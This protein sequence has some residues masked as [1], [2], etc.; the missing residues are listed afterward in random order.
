ML[1]VTGRYSALAYSK[2]RLGCRDSYRLDLATGTSTSIAGCRDEVSPDGL[3][4]ATNDAHGLVLID[5]SGSAA[6]RLDDPVDAAPEAWSPD[7]RW[8]AWLGSF[9]PATGRP[10]E[11]GIVSA[12]GSHRVRLPA[13]DDA[14][15]WPSWSPD[16][17]RV[18]ISTANGTLV[19]RGDGIELKPVGHLGSLT[20]APNGDRFA[21]L[22]GGDLWIARADGTEPTNLTRFES[23]GASAV[24]WSPDGG[25]I[26]VIQGRFAWVVNLYG[27][28]HA[29]DLGADLARGSLSWSPSGGRLAIDVGSDTDPAIDLVSAD[30]TAIA[31]I[32]GAEGPS[33]SPTE[34]YVA[35][36]VRDPQ[37]AGIGVAY[38]DG[39]GLRRWRIDGNVSVFPIRWI[40]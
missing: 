7:G 35:F 29:L 38:A 11:A 14:W 28:R 26:A 1:E 5:S 40:R 2:F 22:Q 13:P 16:G 34:R 31:R 4:I 20:W 3:L 36:R 39:A 30:G 21:Y 19:G 37:F 17:S 6:V 23:G 8:L 25:S 15:D 9:D 33:W 24:A 10:A 12:D 32:D 27:T 18:A